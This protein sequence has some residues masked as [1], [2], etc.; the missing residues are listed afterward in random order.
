MVQIVTTQ[1]FLGSTIETS[2]I[3][4]LA[5]T[6]AK[7]AA[8]A[9]TSSKIAAGAC[10][11]LLYADYTPDTIAKA[12]ASGTAYVGKSFT[13]TAAAGNPKAITIYFSAE[14]TLAGGGTQAIDIVIDGET[15]RIPLNASGSDTLAGYIN[16]YTV[17]GTN[18]YA[19]AH[20]VDTGTLVETVTTLSSLNL[21]TATSIVMQKYADYFGST[22]STTVNYFEVYEG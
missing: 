11:K 19:V 14:S 20:Y 9:V 21:A 2:E 5:V 16:I 7:L 18:A 17:N 1:G 22:G 13:T 15:V 6:N 4:A 3:T 8:D 10:N 12:E